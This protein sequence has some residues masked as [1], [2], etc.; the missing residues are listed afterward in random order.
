MPEG[1]PY[2]APRGTDR[3]CPNWRSEAVYRLLYNNLENAERPEDLVVY[4]GTGRAARSQT[5]L[6]T[7]T[8][9]LQGLG[10]EE[11]L[12]VQSGRAQATFPTHEDAPR[13]LIANSN[14][15][16]RWSTWEHFHELEDEGL[17]MYGQMTAG[18]WCYIGTQGIIQG[19]YETM[20]A[21]GRKHFDGTLAGKTVLTGGL[22]GMGGAQ[23]LAV[24]IAGGACLAVEAVEEHADKRIDVG[25][26]Q[27]KTHDLEEAVG[28]VEDAAER[29][30]ATSVALVG[31][32]AETHPQLLE[33]G[34]EPDLVTD[35]TSAHDA[36]EGYLPAGYTPAEADQLREEDP[37]KYEEA[38]RASMVDH[39]RAM[40]EFQHRGS[41]VFD[42]GNNLRG[43]AADA[44][45]EQ[46]FS[47]PGFVK[48]YVRPMFCQGRGPFRWVALTGEEEDIAVTD[49]LVTDLFGDDETLVRWI[50]A[51]RERVPFEGLPARVCWLG[52]GQRERFAKEIN[53]RVRSGEIGPVAIT[54]DHLDTGSVASPYRE[55]EGMK[56]GS[57]A[58]ADWP[59]LN[60][61]LNASAGADMVAI[62]N[63]GGVGIGLST[64]AGMMVVA[65][66]TEDAEQRI[67][68]VFTA[69]PGSGVVRHADAGYETAEEIAEGTDDFERWG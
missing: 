52:F 42:Y 67:G 48:A 51:A 26:C 68:N 12:L 3:E 36:L 6:A 35:Q 56:D 37:D 24:E 39:C 27:H 13:V 32:C 41:V 54:R 61:L 23:P 65:D 38:A 22:G 40:V 55:T 62:H 8:E 33:Q 53:D 47:Y 46:A 69:D 10:D 15:V 20:A 63:G 49:D 5:D 21:V 66:G 2:R 17:T 16:P 43:Q 11:T 28:I 50:E 7:I 60:A 64:H 30:E 29:G 1:P 18:S 9:A 44:G 14:L 25:Y 31:N 4:G 58:I 34:F 19:T 59:L 57:D 45:Y